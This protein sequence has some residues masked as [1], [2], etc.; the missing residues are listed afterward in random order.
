M[1]TIGLLANGQSLT[2]ELNP[3]VT[4]GGCNTVDVNVDFSDDWDGFSKSAVFFTSLNK[5]AIYEIVMTDGKCVVP[6]EVMEKECMLF[7]GVRGVNSA[8]NEVKTTSLVS[9]R[10][11][12]LFAIILP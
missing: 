3:S 6:S 11:D 9:R 8:N 5:N 10:I 2:V 12:S 7:I 1:T 4:S